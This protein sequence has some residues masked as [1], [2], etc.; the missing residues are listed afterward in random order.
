MTSNG[1]RPPA[2]RLLLG[3]AVLAGEKLHLTE[4]P[5]A[6]PVALLVGLAV[7]GREAT[8]Q[9]VTRVRRAMPQSP[10]FLRGFLEETGRKGARTIHIGRHD[11]ELWLKSA[12]DDGLA[13]A[14]KS[15]IPK[16]IDDMTPKLM[17]TIRQT[18]MPQVI[19][20]LAKDSRIRSLIAEQ[21]HGMVTEAA[22]ELRD[23]SSKA[24]DR[25]EN[26]FRRIFNMSPGS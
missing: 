5:P 7:R 9:A 14:E 21:S 2:R 19:D 6:R 18:I 22:E 1:E 10:G 11:A 4:G 3:A 17:T 13:W 24:D 8:A 12:L 23:S 20:D 15:V 25:V 16:V 26:A